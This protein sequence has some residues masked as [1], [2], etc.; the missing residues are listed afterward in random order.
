MYSLMLFV[1]VLV[2]LVNVVLNR[3]DQR[4]QA[5]RRR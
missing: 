5:R 2:T 1:L 4:F 3:I